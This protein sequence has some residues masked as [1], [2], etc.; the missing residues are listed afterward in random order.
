MGFVVNFKTMQ[1]PTILMT[2][3]QIREYNQD[4]RH[5]AS[6]IFIIVTSIVFIIIVINCHLAFKLDHQ[7]LQTEYQQLAILK[8]SDLAQLYLRGKCIVS[9]SIYIGSELIIIGWVFMHELSIL[10]PLSLARFFLTQQVICKS[11]IEK[12]NFSLARY[13]CIRHQCSRARNL[14]LTGEI[15]FQLRPILL[16]LDQISVFVL[17]VLQRLIKNEYQ[18]FQGT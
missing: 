15:T 2:F 9:Q 4:Y 8:L 1:H 6:L 12:H 5:R 13:F 18:Q 3:F 16:S 11:K 14:H 7:V 17:L 10:P